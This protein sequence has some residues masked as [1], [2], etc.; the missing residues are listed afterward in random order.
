MRSR[1]TGSSYEQIAVPT[2]VGGK[3]F[4]VPDLS[5]PEHRALLAQIER[6]DIAL[7]CPELLAAIPAFGIAHLF[8]KQTA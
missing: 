1:I 4:V 3:A 2:P 8:G 7:N 6:A 5:N